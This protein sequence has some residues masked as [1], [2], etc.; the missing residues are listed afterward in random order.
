MVQEWFCEHNKEFE[1]LTRPPN[2]DLVKG[3]SVGSKSIHRAD[4]SQLK[5]S[6]QGAGS[7]TQLFFFFFCNFGFLDYIEI[8]SVL[9]VLFLVSV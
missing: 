3:G 5:G 7:V 1:V 2:L 9:V 4:T 8:C 6:C